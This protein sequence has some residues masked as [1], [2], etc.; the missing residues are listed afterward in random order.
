MPSPERPGIKRPKSA[1]EIIR[2]ASDDV[3]SLKRKVGG[4]HG[5]ADSIGT[6]GN[7]TV[8]HQQQ[9]T[10]AALSPAGDS[11]SSNGYVGS[12]PPAATE[13]SGATDGGNNSVVL[14]Q[15]YRTKDQVLRERIGLFQGLKLPDDMPEGPYSSFD[16]LFNALDTWAKNLNIGGGAFSLAKDA[17]RP[18]TTVRGAT[19]LIKCSCAGCYR[20]RE[21][22]ASH[23]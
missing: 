3:F 9:H 15:K 7:V 17:R 10:V 16:K 6:E 13:F 1:S 20:K 12:H 4:I 2:C 14:N 5:N 22:A 19:Q 8:Q 18:A 21:S 23:K 11:T